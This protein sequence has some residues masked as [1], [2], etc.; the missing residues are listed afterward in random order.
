MAFEHRRDVRSRERAD[1][2]PLPNAISYH[3]HGIP[4]C[5]T[6]VVDTPGEHS[7]IIGYRF[8]GHP[9]Y[10]PQDVDG[11]EPTDLDEC[12]GH[13]GPNPSSRTARTATTSARRRTTSPRA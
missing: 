2:D 5:V 13:F 10:G 4:F 8:D 11:N 9:I 6:D 1:G 7:V 3:Y 12:M